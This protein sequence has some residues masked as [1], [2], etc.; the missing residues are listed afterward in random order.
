V[1][2]GR[3]GGGYYKFVARH[4]GTCLDV[5]WAAIDNGVLLQQADCN[6]NTAQ[7]FLLVRQ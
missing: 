4:S 5:P 1:D 2:A 6:G 3:A 7:S